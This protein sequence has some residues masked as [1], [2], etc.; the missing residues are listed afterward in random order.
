MINVLSG[1]GVGCPVMAV[2]ESVEPIFGTD[3]G[4]ISVGVNVMINESKNIKIIQSGSRCSCKP[5]HKC[6]IGR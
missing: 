3:D 2:G 5:E 4:R 6:V 1:S